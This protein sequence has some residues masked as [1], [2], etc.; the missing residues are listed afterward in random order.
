MNVIRCS[1]SLFVDKQDLQTTDT[2]QCPLP[3]CNYT[4]CK[5]CHQE[6]NRTGPRHSCDGSSELNHLMDSSG[7]KY[8]PSGSLSF[9][10][11]PLKIQTYFLACRTAIEKSSGC[12]HMTAGLVYLHS[13]F[14]RLTNVI[15]AYLADAIPISVTLAARLSFSPWYHPT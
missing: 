7:W 4:W 10:Q 12:N 13:N 11:N 8:C 14:T 2:I 6:V 1:Q 15:S 3:R 9:A 5:V